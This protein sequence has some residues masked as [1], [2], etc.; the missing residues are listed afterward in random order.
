M[1]LR[2][3]N[4]A[5][6]IVN[7]GTAAVIMASTG[8]ILENAN[9]PKNIINVTNIVRN[10]AIRSNILDGGVKKILVISIFTFI[11]TSAFIFTSTFLF[12][13]LPIQLSF[14][15]VLNPLKYLCVDKEKYLLPLEVLSMQFHL[16]L[17]W[18]L[19]LVIIFYQ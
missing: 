2:S 19:S 5:Q 7:E 13:L 3:T 16:V 4:H 1:D 18:K 9:G 12:Y 11:F 15:N 6:D 10:N 14:L 8:D 17:P